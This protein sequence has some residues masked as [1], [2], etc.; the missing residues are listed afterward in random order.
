MTE[1]T[2]TA[3]PVTEASTFDGSSAFSPMVT[4]G[5]SI[6]FGVVGMIGNGG[7]LYIAYR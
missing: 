3:Y 4:H 5:I 1:E 6:I 2:D 7:V